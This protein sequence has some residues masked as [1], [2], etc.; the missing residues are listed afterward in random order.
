MT[1]IKAGLPGVV[2]SHAAC[3]ARESFVPEQAAGKLAVA[4]TGQWEQGTQ[5][6]NCQ[7]GEAAVAPSRTELP[8]EVQG[9]VPVR[10]TEE[11]Q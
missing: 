6:A 9:V 3:S 2:S 8:G 10:E 5:P 4:G 7:S 1:E 11:V